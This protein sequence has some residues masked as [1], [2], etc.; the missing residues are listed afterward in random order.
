VSESKQRWRLIFRR[1]ESAM[2]LS[3]LDA[4]HA[5]ERGLR[6]GR[7]PVALSEGFNP[8][9]KL[10][11]AAPLQLG[12]LA[13]HELADLYLAERL[14]APD[15]RA[16]LAGCLPPGYVVTDLHDVWVGEAAIAPQLAAADYR[17]TVIGVD[18]DRLRPAI[19]RLLGADTLPRERR[20]EKGTTRY[21]LR[22]L[23][24]DL[25]CADPTATQRHAAN[26]GEEPGAGPAAA[27]WMRLRHSQDGGTGRLEEV[28]AALA[29]EL[30]LRFAWMG[31][32]DT[33]HA[34][35]QAECAAPV[36]RDTGNELDVFMPVRERLWLATELTPTTPK[37]PATV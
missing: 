1:D 21:D 18:V 34:H 22:P 33:D 8:R 20:R 35:P 24:L 27:L 16:R 14:A 12:M 10:A 23:I 3:H 15:L 30:R 9:P 19:A 26:A 37:A 11:F 17:A 5:W 29:E 28:V 4:I 32:D 6:R 25:R 7:I 13:E 31:T 36:A 2:Y